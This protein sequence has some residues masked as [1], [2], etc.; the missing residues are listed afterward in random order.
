MHREQQALWWDKKYE[1]ELPDTGTERILKEMKTVRKAKGGEVVDRR[2]EKSWKTL[3]NC[4]GQRRHW[5]AG[6]RW[7]KRVF[8]PNELFR[9]INKRCTHGHTCGEKVRH[10]ALNRTQRP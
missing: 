6:K 10:C 5:E 1:C 3:L 4:N 2:E 8:C 9:R 7:I